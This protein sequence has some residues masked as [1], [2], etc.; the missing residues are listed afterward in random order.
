MISHIHHINFL[1]RDLAPAVEKHRRLLGIE[2]IYESLPGRGVETA[3]FDVGGTWVVFVQP[4][5]DEG[6]PARHLKTHGEGVF[7]L[8]YGTDDLETCLE[9]LERQGIPQTSGSARRGLSD[10]RV[11]DV[12]EEGGVVLQVAEEVG[13]GKKGSGG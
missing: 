3:R 5:G 8:S 1:V 6:V 4:T 10:W 7:L 12:G 11:T 9:G 2:P 13:G